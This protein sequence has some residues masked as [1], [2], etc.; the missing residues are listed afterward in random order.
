MEFKFTGLNNLG[1]EER[2]GGEEESP[3]KYRV[4]MGNKV[5]RHSLA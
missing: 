1:D 2:R 5:I 4:G 3:L